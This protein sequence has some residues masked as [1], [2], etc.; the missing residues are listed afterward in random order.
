ML[1][2]LFQLTMASPASPGIDGQMSSVLG[3]P[4]NLNVLFASQDTPDSLSEHLKSKAFLPWLLPTFTHHTSLSPRAMLIRDFELENGEQKVSRKI[5]SSRGPASASYNIHSWLRH[6]IRLSHQRSHM[7]RE[8]WMPLVHVSPSP[9][10]Q[11]PALRI[12]VWS[13]VYVAVCCSS[14]PSLKCWF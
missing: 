12:R 11:F 3:Y 7:R 6:C 2:N 4:C 9:T 14:C 1:R 5:H 8:K 10:F 13:V